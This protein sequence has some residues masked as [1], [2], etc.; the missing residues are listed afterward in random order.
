[1]TDDPAA[2]VMKRLGDIEASLVDIRSL[3]VALTD[4]LVEFDEDPD[5]AENAARDPNAPL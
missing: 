4:L 3:I 1:M 2:V 5:P